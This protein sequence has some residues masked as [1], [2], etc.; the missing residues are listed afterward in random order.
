MSYVRVTR[1]LRNHET[2]ATYARAVADVFERGVLTIS[3]C[4]DERE[5]DT[6]APGDWK[7]ADV[8]DDNGG[9]MYRLE[10]PA[11]PERMTA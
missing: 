2:Y 3:A 4:D 10:A 8:V 5:L 6:F 1:P 9:F 7:A 11:Q